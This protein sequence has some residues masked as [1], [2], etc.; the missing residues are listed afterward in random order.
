MSNVSGILETASVPLVSATWPQPSPPPAVPA[1]PQMD[2]TGNGS[3]GA[4]WLFL[5]SALARGVSGIF[6]WTA[7][8]LTCHQ[9]NPPAPEPPSGP[10]SPRDVAVAQPGP[11]GCCC[12]RCCQKWDWPGHGGGDELPRTWRVGAGPENGEVSARLRAEHPP[13]IPG[14]FTGSS[15]GS[16]RS[17]V[18]S[19]FTDKKTESQ[20][21]QR[22]FPSS[23]S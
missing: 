6:V 13:G 21:D 8:V 15:P 9:V 16:L 20:R 14:Y 19:H 17:A 18:W 11:A 1:G 7:L 10:Q 3:Q 4:P 5:T 2:H 12:Y 22:P 23:R